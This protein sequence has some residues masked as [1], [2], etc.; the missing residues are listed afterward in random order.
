MHRKV[1]P[2]TEHALCV[3]NLI[4]LQVFPIQHPILGVQ[5]GVQLIFLV[6]RIHPERDTRLTLV[7]FTVLVRNLK[8]SSQCV[9]GVACVG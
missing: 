9:K 5:L 8:L 3:Q 4:Q 7:L 6:G 1:S 2:S